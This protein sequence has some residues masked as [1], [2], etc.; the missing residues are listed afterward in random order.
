MRVTANDGAA[1]DNDLKTFQDNEKT[2]PTVLTTSR[3]LS[4]GVDARNERNIVLMRPCNNMIEFKQIVGRGTRL[5]EG[6]DYFT[7]YDFVKAHYNF[8]DPEWDGEPI[9]EEA[10]E[11]KDPVIQREKPEAPPGGNG[12]DDLP[13]GEPRPEK[14]TIMLS[15]GKA[16]QIRHISSAMYW[17]PDG[18]P[19]TAGEFVTR[20]FDELP[21]FFENQDKLREIWSDPTTR[22]KLLNDLSEAGYDEEKL[23]SMK[24]LIDARDS[25]VYDVLAFVAYAAETRTRM[26]RVQQA[27]PHI[28]K[29]F[30]DYKQQAFIDF[31]LSKYVED[32]VKELATTKM[33]S[34]IELKYNTIS[35]A[36]AEMGSPAQ[37]RETFVGFQKYLYIA[38]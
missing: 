31:I 23:D 17:S 20:M 28:A 29:A 8:A 36:A 1:G 4:T 30:A 6:K 34:L 35:D 21:Q 37:I 32:G 26:E 7:V 16:R 11:P 9:L 38:D 25:D 13:G 15:D 22:E 24:E 27:K 12:G 33:R 2:I 5:Y 14:I 19:I 10:K 3:K 18:K